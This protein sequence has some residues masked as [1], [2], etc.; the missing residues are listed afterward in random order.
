[1]TG[2]TIPR[3]KRNLLA[4]SRLYLPSIEEQMVAIDAVSEIRRMR[5]E[6]AELESRI[7]DRPREASYVSEAIGKV[8]HEDRFSDWTETLPFPLASILRAYHAVDRTPNEKYERLLYFFEAFAVFWA[9][10]H[11]SAVRTRDPK[12]LAV[13]EKLSL[14]CCAATICRWR[15]QRSEHGKPSPKH[16]ERISGGCSIRMMIPGQRRG[17]CTQ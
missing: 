6:L 4:E 17:S 10:I 9:T 1:M 14:P 13:K 5:S 2:S 15:G 3:I 7:W 12:W 16:L 8:N 11:L